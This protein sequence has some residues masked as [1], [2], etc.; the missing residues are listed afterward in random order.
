MSI[1]IFHELKTDPQSW[2]DVYAGFKTHEVRLNDRNYRIGDFLILNRTVH[3]AAEM[4]AGAPLLFSG[5]RLVV[6]VTHILTGYGL[7][8]GWVVMSIKPHI[9]I[10]PPKANHG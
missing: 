8:P 5:R 1:P 10:K 7:L 3:S 9:D 4:K 6:Q 2:D